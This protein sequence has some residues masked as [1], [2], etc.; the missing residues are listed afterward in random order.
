MDET[1]VDRIQLGRGFISFLVLTYSSEQLIHIRF[2][3]RMLTEKL[4]KTKLG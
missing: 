4:G 2:H 3:R 1:G